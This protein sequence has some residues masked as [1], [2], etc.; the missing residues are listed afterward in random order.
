MLTTNTKGDKILDINACHFHIQREKNYTNNVI[1][2]LWNDINN[3]IFM[4]KG[5]FDSNSLAP[6]PLSFH[7]SPIQL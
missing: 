1:H 4:S 5:F 6:P 2:F 3:M 7:E